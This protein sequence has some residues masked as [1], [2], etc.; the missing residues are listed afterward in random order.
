[1]YMILI[2][3]KCEIY[4]TVDTG[5]LTYG[6]IILAHCCSKQTELKNLAVVDGRHESLGTIQPLVRVHR[7]HTINT[8]THNC[9][10]RQYLHYLAIN[11][12]TLL[13]VTWLIVCASVYVRMFVCARGR[14]CPK[15]WSINRCGREESR[16]SGDFL[17]RAIE[18]RAQFRVQN[19]VSSSGREFV[20]RAPVM[21]VRACSR[22][23]TRFLTRGCVVRIYNQYYCLGWTASFQVVYS[24][25]Y[26][27]FCVYCTL[28]EG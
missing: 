7:S 15:T 17:H 16:F 21:G 3:D 11:F 22:V 9:A 24:E 20:W 19:G 1:M 12:F 4:S 14:V 5:Q 26:S 27:V 13:N 25:Q 18:N 10:C 6:I 23:M 28:L 8:S 2:I